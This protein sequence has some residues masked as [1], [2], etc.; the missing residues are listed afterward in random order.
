MAVAVGFL[1]AALSSLELTDLLAR[2]DVTVIRSGPREQTVT[3]KRGAKVQTSG[4]RPGRQVAGRASRVGS[5]YRLAGGRLVF[6]Q[7]P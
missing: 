2:G 6:V 1:L 4:L 5:V 7:G 3:V